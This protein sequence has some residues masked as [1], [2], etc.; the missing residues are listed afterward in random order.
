M[1]FERFWHR[2]HLS[3]YSEYANFM[4]PRCMLRNTVI[5]RLLMTFSLFLISGL[6]HQVTSRQLYPD[7]PDYA[8]MKF[9]WTNAVAVSLE[10][11]LLRLAPRRPPS[12]DGQRREA[13]RSRVQRLLGVALVRFVGYVWVVS[14]F[15][16]T[17]PKSYYPRV[18]CTV[19][20]QLQVRKIMA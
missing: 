1:R 12:E 20:R 18:H 11:V 15:V 14:F 19:N 9:F 10:S 3:S 13:R 7:C 4:L 2:L 16:W 8:D 17:I 5:K 6:V